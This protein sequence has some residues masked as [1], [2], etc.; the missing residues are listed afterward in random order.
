MIFNQTRNVLYLLFCLILFLTY[1]VVT[2]RFNLFEWTAWVAAF[3]KSRDS[4][5]LSKGIF[6]TSHRMFK[7][8][9]LCKSRQFV[10][11]LLLLIKNNVIVPC[12][13]MHKML[14][15]IRRTREPWRNDSIK[16]SEL[17]SVDKVQWIKFSGQSSVNKVQ[18]A[19]FS[20]QSSVIFWIKSS[21]VWPGL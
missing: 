11:I 5:V 19:K 20:G 12:F 9:N 16:F 2:N 4:L 6:L 3:F 13:A 7:Q 1:I 10:N 17:S 18:W 8:N 14:S 15:C 21:V